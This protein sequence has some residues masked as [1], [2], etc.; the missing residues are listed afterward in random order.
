MQTRRHLETFARNRGSALPGLAP[1]QTPMF[2]MRHL[3]HGD[4]TRYAD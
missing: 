2:A 3:E 1:G 4:G